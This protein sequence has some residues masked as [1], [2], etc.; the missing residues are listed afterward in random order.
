[1]DIW[2]TIILS[3]GYP[4]HI[5]LRVF[6]QPPSLCCAGKLNFCHRLG[7]EVSPINLVLLGEYMFFLTNNEGAFLFESAVR[8]QASMISLVVWVP[9]HRKVQSSKKFYFGLEITP[10]LLY[11]LAF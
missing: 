3:G 11:R 7:W 9:S 6:T 4:R 2:G 10:P 1:M 5:L 8:I